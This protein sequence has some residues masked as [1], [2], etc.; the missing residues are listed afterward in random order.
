MHAHSYH[1]D[2]AE[3]VVNTLMCLFSAVPVHERRGAVLSG[4]TRESAE[5]PATASYCTPTTDKEELN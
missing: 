1:S 4:K 3:T 2:I 5:C